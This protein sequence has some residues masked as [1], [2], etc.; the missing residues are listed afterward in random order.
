VL[1]GIQTKLTLQQ[2][3][4]AKKMMLIWI[5]K[6]PTDYQMMYALARVYLK[7]QQETEAYDLLKQAIA[8]GFSYYWVLQND[9]AWTVDQK[10][11]ANWKKLTEKVKQPEIKE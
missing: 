7:T 9:P 2:Y 4:E 10:Q 8:S 1:I 11:S 3:E 6:H 5:Q